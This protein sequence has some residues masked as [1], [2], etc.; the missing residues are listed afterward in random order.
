MYIYTYIIYIYTEDGGCARALAPPA[1]SQ[2]R[3]RADLEQIS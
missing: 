3:F 1:I 2:D